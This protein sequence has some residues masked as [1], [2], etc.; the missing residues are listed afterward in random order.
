MLVRDL[1][2]QGSWF[3]DNLATPI[4]DIIR[5]HVSHIPVPM[6][7]DCDDG[8]FWKGSNSG[9]YSAASGY[10]WLLPDTVESNTMNEMSWLWKVKV[11]EKI[12][13]LLWLGINNAIPTG[14]FRF[15]R[16]LCDTSVCQ[17]CGQDRDN[18]S[19]LMRL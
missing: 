8:W 16:N 5:N 7:I 19:L 11:L 2:R 3:F 4:P 1:W 6:D 12:K 10:N 14:E 13:L 15:V 17:R 9:V 18:S